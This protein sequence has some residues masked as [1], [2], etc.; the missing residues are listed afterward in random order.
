MNESGELQHYSK[1]DS[2]AEMDIPNLDYFIL[3]FPQKQLKNQ[4]RVMIDDANIKLH[5]SPNMIQNAGASTPS[6]TGV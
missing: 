1:T 3:T 2:T 6:R 4:T 5:Y